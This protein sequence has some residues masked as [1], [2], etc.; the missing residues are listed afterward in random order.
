M[1]GNDGDVK[2]EK[3][4]KLLIVLSDA[5][6]NPGAVMIHFT[7]ASGGR[8]AKSCREFLNV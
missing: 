3:D 5:I 4:E 2:S 1:D 7:H 8:E 6:I